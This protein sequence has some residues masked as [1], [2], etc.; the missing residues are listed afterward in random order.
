[1]L[2]VAGSLGLALAAMG[3]APASSRCGE[4]PQGA[5][6]HFARRQADCGA[7]SVEIAEAEL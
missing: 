6:V 1:M 2:I 4:L 5:V 3:L 7:G